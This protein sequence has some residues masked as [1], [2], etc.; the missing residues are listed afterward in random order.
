MRYL[1][2]K[3]LICLIFLPFIL[4]FCAVHEP[5]EEDFYND[6]SNILGNEKPTTPQIKSF[7]Y[8][9]GNRILSWTQSTD[10]DTG[11]PAS[12]YRIYYY[13]EPPV[14]FYL[15]KDIAIELENTLEFDITIWLEN[16]DL[17]SGTQYFT[18]TAYH[19]NRESEHSNILEFTIP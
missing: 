9:S 4:I 2:K 17:S 6:N 18:V 14:T 12:S 13:T 16:G 15:E 11:S 5:V 1:N 8:A 7:D 10:P 19:D 3:I